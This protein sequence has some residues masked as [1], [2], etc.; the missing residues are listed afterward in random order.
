MQKA[1]ST[2]VQD[3][4]CSWCQ[5]LD[6]CMDIGETYFL[7]CQG[8]VTKE[9]GMCPNPFTETT[10]VD[11]NLIVEGNDERMGGGIH[12]FGPCNKGELRSELL[13]FCRG[14]Q[15]MDFHIMSSIFTQSTCVTHIPSLTL[16]NSR[17][18]QRRRIP[19]PSPRRRILRRTLRWS[20][21]HLRCRLP[22]FRIVPSFRRRY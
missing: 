7:H 2:C 10:R 21:I 4:R 1:C 17:R 3:S 13:M 5:G 12:V 20:C 8:K 15:M 6:K 16:P 9:S 19:L 14:L 11:G 18:L 22:G